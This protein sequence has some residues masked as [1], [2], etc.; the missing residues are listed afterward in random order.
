MFFAD[1][2]PSV[3]QHHSILQKL[4]DELQ[5]IRAPV[6]R[7][8][9]EILQEIFL[10]MM[11]EFGFEVVFDNEP[12][13]AVG[14]VCRAWRTA[15]LCCPQMWC[16]LNLNGAIG[17]PAHEA[18][19]HLRSILNRTR[20]LP[21]SFKLPFNL[22]GP[23]DSVS[24]RETL[25]VLLGVLGQYSA[26]WSSVEFTELPMSD[27]SILLSVYERVPLLESLELYF[28]QPDE[29]DVETKITTVLRTFEVAPQLF[30]VVL[31]NVPLGH[32]ALPPSL[33]SLTINSGQDSWE[34]TM[35]QVYSRTTPPLHEILRH[36]PNLRTVDVN[37]GFFPTLENIARPP[38]PLPQRTVHNHLV[39]LE[40]SDFVSFYHVSLP[41]L[42]ELRVG[43]HYPDCKEPL[44]DFLPAVSSLL[45]HSHCPLSRLT[46]YNGQWN[47]DT[48]C[49]VLSLA[50]QVEELNI[51]YFWHSEEIVLP[52]LHA[53]TDALHKVASSDCN[54]EGDMLRCIP[55]FLPAL[56][57][58][59]IE[60]LWWSFVNKAFVEMTARRWC[61]DGL[62]VVQLNCRKNAETHPEVFPELE[63]CD[64]E[65]LRA[66]KKWGLD[67]SW[68]RSW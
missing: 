7:I 30:R 52:M 49:D 51:V 11:G 53:L 21:L 66:M 10:A 56:K 47:V 35:F 36:Y 42:Q 59:T 44:N 40:T 15:S 9:P 43:T 25:S 23:D 32:V 41:T 24:E 29:D 17:Y 34:E 3:Q 63:E 16:D 38:L 61:K 20:G 37:R 39:L 54:R 14:R 8:P 67:I 58:L 28:D 12:Y 18:E 50:Q 2:D 13:Y 22:Y 6:R 55:T 68:E 1:P 5:I 33:Q 46:L 60:T 57:I 19:R 65:R 26:Q 64:W 4:H 31:H 62:R 48:L 27:A 45:R